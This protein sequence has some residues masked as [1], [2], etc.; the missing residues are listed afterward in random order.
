MGQASAAG[1]GGRDLPVSPLQV[2]VARSGPPA[3]ESRPGIFW[4][5]FWDILALCPVAEKGP[6]GMHV[7]QDVLGER[8]GEGLGLEA[9]VAS[10]LCGGKRDSIATG[11]REHLLNGEDLRP[12]TR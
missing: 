7:A 11:Q 1:S 12:R 5:F 6:L 8:A 10:A 2:G 3:G 4:A 9:L